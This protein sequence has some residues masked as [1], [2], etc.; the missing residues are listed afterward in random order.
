MPTSCKYEVYLEQR[1]DHI[2]IPRALDL[3]SP[4]DASSPDDKSMN[5]Y[6]LIERYRLALIEKRRR[7]H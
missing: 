4:D 3:R 6:D 1:G 7:D 2:K 5:S